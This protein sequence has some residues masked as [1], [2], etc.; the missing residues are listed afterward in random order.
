MHTLKRPIS[1]LA[2]SPF[3]FSY[4]GFIVYDPMTHLA[5][6]N[7]RGSAEGQSK[8]FFRSVSLMAKNLPRRM[9]YKDMSR[10]FLAEQVLSKGKVASES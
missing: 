4:N 9:L 2:R 5:R 8:I 7:H 6:A 10:S 1:L 3:F